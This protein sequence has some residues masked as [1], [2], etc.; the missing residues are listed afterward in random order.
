VPA[1]KGRALIGKEWDPITWNG[2]VWRDP[3]ETKNFESS[4]SQGF[5]SPVEVVPSAPPLEILP[6]SHEEIN[7]SVSDKPAVI[8]SEGNAEQDNTDVPQGPPIVS[9]RPNQT[10][11]KVGS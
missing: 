3:V 5:T 2:E 9:S 7:P 11:S 4:D 6:F 8:F 10:Q 1:V